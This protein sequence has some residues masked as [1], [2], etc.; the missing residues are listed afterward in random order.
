MIR[1]RLAVLAAFTLSILLL[2]YG[3]MS[4]DAERMP[5][6]ITPIATSI[7]AG[8]TYIYGS[9][10]NSSRTVSMRIEPE[11]YIRANLGEPITIYLS[12]NDINEPEISWEN[13]SVILG[14]IMLFLTICFFG[15]SD[16]T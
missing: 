2:S 13:I 11:K 14:F 10:D 9:V 5:R 7:I 8:K 16:D 4:A 15:V 6:K 12:N 1:S 3:S